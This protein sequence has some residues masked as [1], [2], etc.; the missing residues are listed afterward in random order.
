MGGLTVTYWTWH[1]LVS[2]LR[3]A[4]LR[5]DDADYVQASRVSNAMINK[6]P[7]LITRCV[8]V[9]DVIV[10]INSGHLRRRP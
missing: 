5:R 8:D 7:A 4:L 10:A 1:N 9:A 2:R 6:Q 3:G